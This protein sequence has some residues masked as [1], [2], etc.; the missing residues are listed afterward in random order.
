MFSH[1]REKDWLRARAFTAQVT[2]PRLQVLSAARKQ[3][4]AISYVTSLVGM[5]Q[6]R[7]RTLCSTAV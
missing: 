3:I 1:T 7:R 2:G 4:T 5:W 6:G